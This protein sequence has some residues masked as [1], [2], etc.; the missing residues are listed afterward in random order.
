MNKKLIIVSI[1][2]FS[3]FTGQAFAGSNGCC[4]KTSC[5]CVQSTC[6]K[7]GKCGCKGNCCNDS[8]CACKEGK[9]CA[10]GGC[11]AK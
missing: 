11:A 5:D 9:G 3:L 10:Q 1:L 6:C 4:L 8:S 7:D 2:L